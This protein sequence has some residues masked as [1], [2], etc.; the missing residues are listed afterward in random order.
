[1]S[2]TVS[3]DSLHISTMLSWKQPSQEAGSAQLTLTVGFD[4]VETQQS[5]AGGCTQVKVSLPVWRGHRMSSPHVEGLRSRGSVASCSVV[6]CRTCPRWEGAPPPPVTTSCQS[7]GR[8]KINNHVRQRDKVLSRVS[9]AS[10][11][12]SVVMWPAVSGG[13][14]P[15]LSIEEDNHRL[16]G[17]QPR[18]IATAATARSRWQT[19]SVR[20]ADRRRCTTSIK[21]YPTQR[22][23]KSLTWL[24]VIVKGRRRGSGK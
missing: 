11:G 17:F 22:S 18:E 5:R 24:S 4:Q 3:T 16:T 21:C 13:S 7:S 2:S 20:D 12:A 9:A 19:G 15:I 10:D 14:H 1:M 8:N 23:L 6:D